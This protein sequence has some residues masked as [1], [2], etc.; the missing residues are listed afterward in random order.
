MLQH[1]HVEQ[2]LQAGLV[3]AVEVGVLEHVLGFVAEDVDVALQDDLVLGQRAGL[4]GAQHVHRAEVLDRVQALDD[5][6]L[7]RHGER[8]LGQVD[9]DDHRQHLGRQAHGDRHREQERLEPVA[10]GEAVDEEHERHHHQHE[11][12]DQPDEALH[13]ACRSSVS[14]ALARHVWPRCRR[15]RCAC[16][17]SPPPRVAVPLTTLVPMKARFSS[18]SAVFITSLGDGRRE[19]LDRQRFARERGLVHEEVARRE[20]AHVRRD[21]VARRELDDVAGHDVRERNL[22]LLRS[23]SP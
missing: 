21:H 9:R 16:P 23:P 13:A 5:D 11:A 2:V 8:A 6:L 4:V 19:L 7:A 10:L 20:H 22:A 17:S 3:E 12:D 15:S 18:S 14:C 1:R